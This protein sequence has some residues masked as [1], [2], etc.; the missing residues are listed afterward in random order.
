MKHSRQVKFLAA[1]A[2]AAAA[3]AHGSLVRAG[4]P[5]GPE[6]AGCWS[7]TLG[8]ATD[9]VTLTLGIHRQTDG[10]LTGTIKGLD[11]DN[12]YPI[13]RIEH[14]GRNIAMTVGAASASL[15]G[16]LSQDG[17]VIAG[18][19]T[20]LAVA[21]PLALVRSSDCGPSAPQANQSNDHR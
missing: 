15:A 18:Q 10:A 8:E 12:V 19:W 6:L 17:Q 20:Q 13:D 1:C 2:L 11:Q 21:M 4:G 16:T 9:K 3:M 14:D 5:A 7:G